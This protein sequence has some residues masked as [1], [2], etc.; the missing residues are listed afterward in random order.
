MSDK[1][2]LSN[3]D[4][5]ARIAYAIAQADGDLPGMEPD[6]PDYDLADA[7]ISEL[8]LREERTETETLTNE[9]G[10]TWF[11]QGGYRYVTEWIDNG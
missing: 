9:Q 8:G 11:R 4:L 5:R 7:V 1:P 3:I 2:P 10:A 6:L